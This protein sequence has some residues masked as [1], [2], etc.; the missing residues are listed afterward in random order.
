MKSMGKKILALVLASCLGL[1]C[2]A[3]A[4]AA[5]SAQPWS[6]ALG[7]GSYVLKRIEYTIPEDMSYGDSERLLAVYSATGETV[8]ISGY[9]E[10]ALYAVVPA[11]RADEA[12]EARVVE[13]PAPFTDQVQTW[14]GSEYDQTP[15]SAKNLALRGVLRGNDRGEL[16]PDNTITRAEAFT[17]VTRV[18][19][20]KSAADPG[21]ADAKPGDWY[22]ETAASARACGIAAA[23]FF[24]L[25]YGAQ[26]NIFRRMLHIDKFQHLHPVSL[27]LEHRCPQSICDQRCHPLL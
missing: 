13:N 26:K 6:K 11:G 16:L 9:A 22:Y 24:R 27:L 4:R 23:D 15:L 8:A 21:Y 12:L 3:A 10:D 5:E 17:L 1:L 18:L 19:G 20:V 7:D 2:A 14:N 25:L